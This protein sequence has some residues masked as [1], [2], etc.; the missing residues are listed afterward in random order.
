MKQAAFAIAVAGLASVAICGTSKAAP[1][2]PFPPAVAATSTSNVIPAYYWH[3]RYY[4]YYWHRHYYAHR[5]WYHHHYRY[6]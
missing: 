2:A 4:P 1:I 5:G 6:W 3:G